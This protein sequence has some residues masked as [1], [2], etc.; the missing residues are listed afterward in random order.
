MHDHFLPLSFKFLRKYVGNFLL[1]SLKNNLQQLVLLGHNKIV[2]QKFC[3][4]QK[5]KFQRKVKLFTLAFLIKL[6][7][8]GERERERER[9]R[10][11]VG[12]RGEIIS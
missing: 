1:K 4:K 9:E 2:L 10:E 3:A 5:M 11:G 8:E 12:E 6:I 7:C